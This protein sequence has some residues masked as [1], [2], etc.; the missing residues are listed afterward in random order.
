[1]EAAKRSAYTQSKDSEKR[2]EHEQQLAK[3]K[4][5]EV[6][7]KAKNIKETAKDIK[8]GKVDL[9]EKLNPENLP[10]TEKITSSLQK[11]EESLERFQTSDRGQQM[12]APAQKV[13]EDIKKV[14]SD[15]EV[16]LQK[17][18]AGDLLQ[19]IIIH[20]WALLQ[21]MRRD[22]ALRDTFDQWQSDFT[23]L[24]T[25]GDIMDFFQQAGELFTSLKDTEEF[26]ELL[27]QLIDILK[28]FISEQT[29]QI[30]EGTDTNT[31]LYAREKELEREYMLNNLRHLIASFSNNDVWRLFV[32]KGR[33]LGT[34]AHIATDV[35]SDSAAQVADR[36]KESENFKLLL[37]DFKQLIQRLVGSRRSV[38]PLFDYSAKGL[39]EI[40]DNDELAYLVGELRV[41]LD[42]IVENPA[43]LEDD[44]TQQRLR[45]LAERL[46]TTVD[47]LK[48]S[49]NIVGAKEESKQILAAMK[50][51][52]L[53]AQFAQDLKELW[54]DVVSDKEGEVIDADVL[55]SIR[56]MVVPLLLEHLNNVPLPSVNGSASFLG[57]LKYSIDDMKISLPALIPEH[58][59]L[60]F[61]MNVDAHPLELTAETKKTYLYLQASS[62]QAHLHGAKWSYTRLSTPKMHDSGLFDVDTVGSGI[63][64]W[65]KMELSGDTKSGQALTV[66]K[67]D[68]K[69]PQNFHIK[70]HDSKHDT[71]YA[72]L[73]HVFAGKIK[74]EVIK[75]L[76]EKLKLFGTYFSDQLMTLIEQARLKSVD[77]ANIAKAKKALA[78]TKMQEGVENLK[79]QT[80]NVVDAPSVQESKEEAKSTA[81]IL[82]GAAS[83]LVKD[84]LDEQKTKIE[85]QKRE[86]ELDR[87]LYEGNSTTKNFDS[88]FPATQATRPQQSM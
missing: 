20:F 82:L 39:E 70:F 24:M 71:I 36:V 79:A 88:S 2:V 62:I 7:D 58:I 42:I 77:F 27:S 53:N 34:K 28:T 33:R 6:I 48:D 65:M 83:D 9:K 54:H 72:M 68:V 52:P 45:N 56:Q 86:K 38:E 23:S 32:Y 60:R 25:S 14:L 12:G 40:L 19:N 26:L 76:Q 87:M 35:T 43:L 37:N 11:G 73:S 59:H 16:L 47:G 21:E 69:I 66:V 81:K 1:M 80:K 10:T 49:P 78:Q 13:V 51:D 61:E 5:R 84:K 85:T 18:N 75:M 64:I 50:D 55:S 67:S 8:E 41:L 46:D 44:T 74:K 29:D 22:P 31:E 15:E 63:T 3:E 30:T 4:G 57:K 17:K